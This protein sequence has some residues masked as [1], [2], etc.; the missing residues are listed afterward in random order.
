MRKLATGSRFQISLSGTVNTSFQ[1]RL[2]SDA[3][4]RFQCLTE[5]LQAMRLQVD[6]GFGRGDSSAISE[7]SN[8]YLTNSS[9]T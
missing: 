4:S 1:A 7:L 6:N 5:D 9:D 3:N 2:L 8:I